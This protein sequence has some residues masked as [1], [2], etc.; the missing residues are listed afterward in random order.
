[1]KL[2]VFCISLL[3]M[4]NC[5]KEE[6]IAQQGTWTFT[7]Y[8]Y[9]SCPPDWRPTTHSTTTTKT[10]DETT[11]LKWANETDLLHKEAVERQRGITQILKQN[12]HPDY[13]RENAYYQWLLSHKPKYRFELR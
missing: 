8:S 10:I 11:A 6:A 13:V 5:A 2:I 12:N 9:S 3:V 4:G 1:M 7:S